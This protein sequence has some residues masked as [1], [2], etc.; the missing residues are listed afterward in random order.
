MALNHDKSIFNQIATDIFIITWLAEYLVAKDL[1]LSERSSQFSIY[2]TS[3]KDTQYKAAG[4][5]A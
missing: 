1:K 5:E 4:N 3:L 2:I